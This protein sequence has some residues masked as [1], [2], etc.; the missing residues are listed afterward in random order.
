MAWTKESIKS[1]EFMFSIDF[2]E[3]EIIN[4]LKGKTYVIPIWN[5][6]LLS[7]LRKREIDFTGIEY[8][9]SFFDLV[10]ELYN[11]DKS[12]LLKFVESI[13]ELEEAECDNVICFSTLNWIDYPVSFM[14]KIMNTIKAKN[15]YFTCD[16]FD[17][18][19]H[20]HL[21]TIA[22]ERFIYHYFSMS[23]LSQ[24]AKDLD[25]K[26]RTNNNKVLLYKEEEK[27]ILNDVKNDVESDIIK[28][29]IVDKTKFKKKGDKK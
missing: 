7:E 12:M 16:V 11:S 6:Y 23:Y 3:Q 19:Y 2:L 24:I 22:L 5:G 28:E 10:N 21:K 14:S 8:R 4:N 9:G 1:N 17:V 25:L 27:N 26:I 29:V 13:D 20:K 18:E 15:Y